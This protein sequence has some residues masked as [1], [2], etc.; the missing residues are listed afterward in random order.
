MRPPPS[1]RELIRGVRCRLLRTLQE[2]SLLRPNIYNFSQTAAPRLKKDSG[3]R[4][5]LALHLALLLSTHHPIDRYT[6]AFGAMSDPAAPSS[7]SAAGPSAPV[8][9][10]DAAKSKQ[11]PPLPPAKEGGNDKKSAKE[12]KAARRAAKVAE[13]APGDGATLQRMPPSGAAAA[14]ARG[15]AADR[16]QQHSRDG[17][18]AGKRPGSSS[19]NAA[20]GKLGGAAGASGAAAGTAMAAAASSS[21]ARRAQDGAAPARAA[22][23]HPSVALFGNVSSAKP[24]NA[25]HCRAG[26]CVVPLQH[27]SVD[28]A[29]GVTAGAVQAHGCRH[30]RDR[31]AACHG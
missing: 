20:S 26:L 13:R 22:P 27:P 12:L 18:P 17:P 15:G 30:A 23:A 29:A 9:A 3:P 8:L 6:C 4:M 31:A 7:A 14:A 21:G 2:C 25:P 11:Q 19:A 5:L 10:P 28:P 1:P 24:H 16:S